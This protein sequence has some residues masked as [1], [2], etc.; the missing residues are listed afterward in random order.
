MY[1]N[2]TY[3]CSYIKVY[4]RDH[5]FILFLLAE[6]VTVFA[7]ITL[8]AISVLYVTFSIDPP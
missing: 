6:Y 8:K 2:D 3:T 4:S 7:A 5:G 1:A